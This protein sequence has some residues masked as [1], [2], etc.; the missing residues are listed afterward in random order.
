ESDETAILAELERLAQRL[1]GYEAVIAQREAI[2]EGF[3]T[4]EAARQAD[5][6][7]SDKLMTLQD[8]E[9]R[10]HALE[11]QIAAARAALEAQASDHRGAIEE[12]ERLAAVEDITGELDRVEGEIRALEAREAERDRLREQTGDLNSEAAGLRSANDALRAEM[13]QI[14]T[15]MDTLAGAAPELAICPTCQQP[16][17]PAQR[18]D[19]LAEYR[20][21]GTQRGDQYRANAARLEDIEA[22]VSDLDARA[23]TLLDELAPLAALRQE[24]GELRARQAAARDAHTRLTAEQSALENVRQALDAGNYAGE[25]RAQLAAL[26]DEIAALGYDRS[27]HADARDNLSA[28][29][30]YERR[31]QELQIALDSAPEARRAQEAASKRLERLRRVRQE[32]SAAF[33][34]MGGEI[35]RLKALVAEANRRFDTAR[36]LRT[37]WQNAG[38]RRARVQ[39]ALHA[40]ESARQ[41]RATLT[42]RRAGLVAEQGTFAQLREAFGRNGIPAM[43]IEAAIPELEDE[44]NALLAR[45]TDGQMQVQLSTQRE[46]VTGGISETLDITIADEAGTRDYALYSGGEAFRIDFALR[47]ALSKLLARRAG[48]QLRTL[49]IDEGFGTQDAQGRERLVEAINAIADDFDLILVIT[50][51]DDLR[52]AFPA[53]LEVEKLP[54]GS[55][56]RLG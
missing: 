27:A 55:R 38:E 14:K 32:D 2:E 19:L 39:Q 42:D 9:A 43:I 29:Q 17:S 50:H 41:R 15:R 46:K 26:Q 7:L 52:D 30:A 8:A 47:I 1:S 48:A 28:Y 45:M 20:A 34:E 12:L 24:A 10:R 37:A 49:F 16:L 21:D 40:L 22:Q 13:H 31:Q 51:I 33:G 25:A 4:L 36:E 23:R 5:Q 56:V 44:T 35:E 53:R 11:Q 54:S 6:S 3:A 18:A